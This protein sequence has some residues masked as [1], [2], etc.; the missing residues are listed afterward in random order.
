MT[1]CPLIKRG[2]IYRVDVNINIDINAIIRIG[3]VY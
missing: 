1:A 3:H 2:P